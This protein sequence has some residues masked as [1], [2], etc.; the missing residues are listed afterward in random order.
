[1]PATMTAA[2]EVNIAE[3][4]GPPAHCKGSAKRNY[5]P[6]ETSSIPGR[7]VVLRHIHPSLDQQSGASS[8]HAAPRYVSVQGVASRRDRLRCR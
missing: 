3:P 2:N 4:T 8:A 7:M 1:M 5:S 6:V